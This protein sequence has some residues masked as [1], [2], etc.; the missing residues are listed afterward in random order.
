MK[1]TLITLALLGSAM[2]AFSQG[3]IQVGNTFGSA[4]LASV[5]QFTE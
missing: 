3:T 1:K 2:V 5:R 4:L